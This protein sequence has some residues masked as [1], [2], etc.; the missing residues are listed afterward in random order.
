MLKRGESLCI[1]GQCF[2]AW[3]VRPSE[4]SD[5]LRYGTSE[6]ADALSR[7]HFSGR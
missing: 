4:G 7:L 5:V 1:L 2:H 3:V 6:L